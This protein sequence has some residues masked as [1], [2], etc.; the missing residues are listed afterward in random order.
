MRGAGVE[1][2]GKATYKFEGILDQMKKAGLILTT[3]PGFVVPI[4]Q[5]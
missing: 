4:G 3:Q 2:E 5:Y 1:I